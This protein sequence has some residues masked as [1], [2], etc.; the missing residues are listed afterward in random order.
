M[1]VKS[2][3]ALATKGRNAGE[4]HPDTSRNYVLIIMAMIM[5]M[6]I[7]MIIS[8]IIILIMSGLLYLGLS[9]GRLDYD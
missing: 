9:L 7:M 4:I 6:I 8:C 2:R 5:I 3:K 1:R